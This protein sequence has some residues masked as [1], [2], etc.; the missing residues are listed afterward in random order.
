MEPARLSM[1]G[2]FGKVRSI[3]RDLDGLGIAIIVRWPNPIHRGN[4]RCVVFIDE[5]ADDAQRKSLSE[6]GTGN[7]GQGGAAIAALIWPS[8]FPGLLR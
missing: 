4:G 8:A 7:A 1:P 3:I 5:L 2:K 6:I